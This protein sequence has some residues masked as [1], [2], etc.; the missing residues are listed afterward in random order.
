MTPYIPMNFYILLH[1]FL[2]PFSV[3]KLVG[4]SIIVEQV[5]VIVSFLSIIRTPCLN[6]PS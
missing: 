2:E 6:K 4:E 5:F 1:Q 3:S